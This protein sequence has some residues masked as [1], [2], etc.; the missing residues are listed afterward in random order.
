MKLQVL[1]EAL[2]NPLITKQGSKIID[3]KTKKKKE[4]LKKKEERLK[5]NALSNKENKK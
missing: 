1:K 3:A 5:K 2:M 4:L